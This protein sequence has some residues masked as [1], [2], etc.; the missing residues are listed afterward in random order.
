[1]ATFNRWQISAVVMSKGLG[2]TLMHWDRPAVKLSSSAPAWQQFTAWNVGGPS[3]DRSCLPRFSV[4]L[5]PG[6]HFRRFRVFAA[7]GDPRHV[8]CKRRS[9]LRRGPQSSSVTFG[10]MNLRTSPLAPQ[11]PS[12][13]DTAVSRA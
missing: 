1:M 13:R 4:Q 9:C 8:H 5:G 2:D 11:R 7:L 6:V 3:L 10:W 12:S